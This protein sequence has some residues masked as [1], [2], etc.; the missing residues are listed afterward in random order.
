MLPSLSGMKRWLSVLDRGMDKVTTEALRITDQARK[1]A[2]IGVGSLAI[3]P[4]AEH[5]PMGGTIRGKVRLELEEPTELE[6]VTLTLVAK[7]E[8]TALQKDANGKRSPV[9]QT[10]TLYSYD[11]PL[12]SGGTYSTETFSFSVPVPSKLEEKVEASGALGDV[13]KLAQ[14]LQA[15]TRGP[16]QWSLHA[17]AEVPWKRNVRSALDV[18]IG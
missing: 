6:G 15:M 8:R 2:G 1:V 18:S 3:H 11:V 5:T 7:Q 13:L 4:A 14:G 12:A 17:T 16:V 9:R 10:E